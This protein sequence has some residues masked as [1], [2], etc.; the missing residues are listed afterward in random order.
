MTNEELRALFTYE[1]S[2]MLRRLDGRKP[3]PWRA[4]GKEG[5][6]RATTVDGKTYYLHRLVWQYH[7]GVVPTMIDH[8]N[9]DASDNRIEN[10]RECTNAQNQYNG[11]RKAHNKSGHKGVVFHPLCTVKPWQA[12]IAQGGKVHSLGY[13]RTKEEAAAA[14]AEGAARIAGE[15]ARAA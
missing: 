9:G 1:D 12:K 2:G 7:F 8:I 15:F 13:Y 5:R 4:I 10:L 11:P 14:Y 6:Y 3:Y